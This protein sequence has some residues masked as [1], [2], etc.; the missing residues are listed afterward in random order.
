MDSLIKVVGK[1]LKMALM[2]ILLLHSDITINE[3]KRE[4]KTPKKTGLQTAAGESN[5]VG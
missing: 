3:R 4:K 2:A 5:N 1:D